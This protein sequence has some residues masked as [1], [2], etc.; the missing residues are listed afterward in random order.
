M[1]MGWSLV[2]AAGQTSTDN[3][4]MSRIFQRLSVQ[5]MS[6]RWVSLICNCALTAAA[7][8][9]AVRTEFNIGTEKP[10]PAGNAWKSTGVIRIIMKA[11][12][13]LRSEL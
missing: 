6:S 8:A 3:T 2:A 10:M 9:V 1:S 4:M 7:V 5:F 12:C 13:K 11:L